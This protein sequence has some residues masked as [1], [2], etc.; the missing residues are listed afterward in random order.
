MSFIQFF[1]AVSTFDHLRSLFPIKTKNKY[2]DDLAKL[3]AI[4]QLEREKTMEDD[5]TDLKLVA[6]DKLE[7]FEKMQETNKDINQMP[8]KHKYEIKTILQ[9]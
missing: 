9:L 4:M 2:K 5:S 6:L 7:E 8:R 3:K 1:V